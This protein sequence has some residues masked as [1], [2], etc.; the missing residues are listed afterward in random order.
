MG[1]RTQDV[2]ERDRDERRR[3]LPLEAHPW[4]WFAALGVALVIVVAA[5]V[6]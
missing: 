3:A 4:G 1:R 2:D 6:W 5:L